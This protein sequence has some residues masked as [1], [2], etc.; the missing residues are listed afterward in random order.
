MRK[1]VDKYL[2]EVANNND[3]IKLIIADVGDFP[4][5][6]SLHPKKFINAG[7][8]ESN[9][10]GLAAGL[11]SEGFQVFVYGVSSFFLYRAHE[12]LKFSVAYWKKNI[13]FIG[14]GFGWKYYNIGI[15]HF[16]PDDI[17]LVQTLPSMDIYTPYLLSQLK[18]VLNEQCINPRYLR[19]TANIVE[20]DA[21]VKFPNKEFVI[22]SYGEMVKSCLKVI[23]QINEIGFDI[24]FVALDNLKDDYVSL[25]LAPF[26]KSTVIVVE[27]QCKRGGIFPQ[28]L[29]K[30][31]YR[32]HRIGL[33]LLP[34]K[35]ANT[36]EELLEMY[37]LDDHSICKK[38]KDI[39]LKY[40]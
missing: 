1:W 29:E 36:R 4:L 14:V 7:V 31:F 2:T 11:S 12:Q 26:K 6:S 22:V 21:C 24:G 18:K 17:L 19:L 37:G 10:I 38:I 35:V 5:F 34:D 15:G 28:L 9:A 30:D 20:E 3:N 8:S 13:T 16:C 40:G 27:D 39:V 23:K 25:S 32:V 33:P